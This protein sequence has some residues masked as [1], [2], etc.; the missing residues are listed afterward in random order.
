MFR[1]E[2][3]YGSET[4][5]DH[6]SRRIRVHQ[7]F[8]FCEDLVCCLHVLNH[9]PRVDFDVAWDVREEGMV[10]SHEFEPQVGQ[11]CQPVK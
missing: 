10:E 9:K 8:D 6:A 5:Q 1:R 3:I 4:H 7:S 11:N 2:T